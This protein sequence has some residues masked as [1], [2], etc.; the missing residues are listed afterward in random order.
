M[1]KYIEIIVLN[2]KTNAMNIESHTLQNN[3]EM[4]CF[5]RDNLLA[6]LKWTDSFWEREVFIYSMVHF[7]SVMKL[8]FLIMKYDTSL[9]KGLVS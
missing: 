5:G 9:A 1:P 3:S 4:F 8:T 7:R 6:F 2:F